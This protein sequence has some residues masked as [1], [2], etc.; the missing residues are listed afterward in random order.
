MDGVSLISDE[1]AWQELPMWRRIGALDLRTA[2]GQGAEAHVR[3]FLEATLPSFVVSSAVRRDAER[4]VL[5]AVARRQGPGV[6]SSVVV[7]CL[8]GAGEPEDS[9]CWSF[10][11]LERPANSDEAGE[12]IE[13]CLYRE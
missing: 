12:V 8:D 5:E 4:S 2:D 10:F 7:T 13:I 3:G 6:Q 9:D 11:M 1:Q